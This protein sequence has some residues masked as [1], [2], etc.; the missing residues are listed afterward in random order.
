MVK[1]NRQLKLAIVD[2][3]SRCQGEKW[4]SVQLTERFIRKLEDKVIMRI[5]DRIGQQENRK[6]TVEDNLKA[7][8][9]ELR[10]AGKFEQTF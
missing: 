1:S 7:I 6:V 10:Q 9:G 8:Q 3:S 2:S 4:T 5:V